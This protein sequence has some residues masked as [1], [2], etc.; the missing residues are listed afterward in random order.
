M[1]SEHRIWTNNSLEPDFWYPVSLEFLND[2][3]IPN[4][5]IYNLKSFSSL[6]VL[7]RLAGELF[8]CLKG[9]V[10]I[11]VFYP[12]SGVWIING[13]DVFYN[14]FAQV[15]F[16]CPM[17]FERYPLDEHICKF[18]VGSTNMDINY[19][20]FGETDFSFNKSAMNTILDYKI[21]A[22]NLR[23][24]DRILLYQGQN[25]SVTGACF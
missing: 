17:R 11:N 25:Y 23:Q 24:T 13:K 16:L 14:Q 1:W 9:R 5:F 3:W 19:M 12:S 15:T 18:R 7:K 2:L 20:R 21:E 6:Q 10:L 4:V 8:K 22:T